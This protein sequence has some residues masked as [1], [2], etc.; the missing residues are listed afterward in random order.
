MNITE[1]ATT[2]S[3]ES[4]TTKNNDFMMF[5]I[6]QKEVSKEE[7]RISIMSKC[8]DK[9]PKSQNL[10]TYPLSEKHYNIVNFFTVR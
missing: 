2:R 7:I 4:T 10:L 3:P 5:L 6:T 1:K 8:K 9:V